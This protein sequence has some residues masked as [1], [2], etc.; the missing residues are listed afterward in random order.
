MSI[1]EAIALLEYFGI[2]GAD[3]LKF[4][5]QYQREFAVLGLL[6]FILKDA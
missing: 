3:L 5:I 4:V 2:S 6:Y 1:I